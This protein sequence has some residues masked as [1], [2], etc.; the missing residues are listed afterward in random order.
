MGELSKAGHENDDDSGD[1]K[2]PIL[3]L[4]SSEE[5]EREHTKREQNKKVQATLG[6]GRK[7]PTPPRRAVTIAT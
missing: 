7:V 4:R 1:D 5:R 3:V 6:H 2:S